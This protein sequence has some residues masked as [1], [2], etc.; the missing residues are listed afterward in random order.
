MSSFGP[1]SRNRREKRKLNERESFDSG[2]C[3]GSEDRADRECS[4]NTGASRRGRGDARGAPFRLG[5]YEIESGRESF[6]R[7]TVAA[8]R[9]GPCARRLPVVGDVAGRG[10]APRA[11][12][13]RVV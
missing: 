10:C 8:K 3:E 5:E 13:R 12:D 4:G 7:E 11:G 9:N 1:R 6:W 2:G